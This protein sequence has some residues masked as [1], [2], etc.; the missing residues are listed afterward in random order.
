MAAFEKVTIEFTLNEA[1]IL[2]FALSSHNPPKRDEMIA[3]ILY[4]RVTKAIEEAN[5]KNELL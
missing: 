1:R 4:A 3:F 5:S 2:A